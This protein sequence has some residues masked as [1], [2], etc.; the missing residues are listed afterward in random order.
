MVLEPGCRALEIRFPAGWL[1][2]QPLTA[3]DLG[4]EAEY[5][6]AIGFALAAA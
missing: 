1:E 5:L 6:G 2:Q 4:Q 3:A